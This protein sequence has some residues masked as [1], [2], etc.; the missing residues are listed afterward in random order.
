MTDHTQPSN[1]TTSA[2]YEVDEAAS[3]VV[4]HTKATGLLARFAHDLE[5]EAPR[6]EATLDTDGD[7]WSATMHF[8]VAALRVVGVLRN[9]GV[10]ET[11]LSP[12]DVDE[13]RQRMDEQVFAKTDRV[14]VKAEGTEPDRGTAS[15]ELRSGRQ[16][17]PVRQ[18]VDKLDDAAVEVAGRLALSLKTLGAKQIKGPLGAFK[19]HDDVEVI[20]AVILRPRGDD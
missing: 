19:V 18:R 5:I 1:G 2:S 12:S 8:P 3:R 20:Y 14:V 16:R 7:R 9:G 4:V 6:F 10:D 11:V 15:I 13:I 17:V